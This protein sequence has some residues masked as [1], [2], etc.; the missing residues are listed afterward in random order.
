MCPGWTE[1]LY[2]KSPHMQQILS[3]QNVKLSKYYAF[4]MLCIQNV[5]HSKI[6]AFK[7][8]CSQKVVHSK[9]YTFIILCIQ[10][11]MQSKCCALK[12]LCIQKNC[13]FKLYAFKMFAG[14]KF[15]IQNVC[16]EILAFKLLHCKNLRWDYTDPFHKSA[17]FCIF[18]SLVKLSSST[19]W[20]AKNSL[21]YS[22][23]LTILSFIT[24][25]DIMVAGKTHTC[26]LDQGF[27]N[28]LQLLLLLFRV[29]I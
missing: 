28:C 15:C 7:V 10:N 3:S 2:K 11:F 20:V 25:V 19:C 29:M 6:Y 12:M 26:S 23:T 9:C 18:L 8:L 1:T 24:S 16:D 5:V 14:R 17:F 4:A 22:L 21:G 13:A 27:T